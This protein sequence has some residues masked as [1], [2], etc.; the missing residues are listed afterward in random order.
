MS[1]DWVKEAKRIH[2]ELFS[3][4]ESIFGKCRNFTKEEQAKIE[5]HKS[6]CF[7]NKAKTIERKRII[8]LKLDEKHMLALWFT[9]QNN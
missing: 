7:K 3:I 9:C 8:P 6:K 4:A 5:E 2:E 1:D